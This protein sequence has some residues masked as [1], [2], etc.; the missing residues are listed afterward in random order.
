MIKDDPVNQRL[1]E[2]LKNFRVELFNQIGELIMQDQNKGYSNPNFAI[3]EGDARGQKINDD[4]ML[5][6]GVPKNKIKNVVNRMVC[7]SK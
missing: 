6:R 1:S 2:G 5:T 3:V 7:S 4:V